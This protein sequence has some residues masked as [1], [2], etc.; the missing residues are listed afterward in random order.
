MASLLG[1][2]LIGRYSPWATPCFLTEEGKQG[3]DSYFAQAVAESEKPALRDSTSAWFSALTVSYLIHVME[4]KQTPS[5][6]P[7]HH[8]QQGL[9]SMP[10]ARWWKQAA[11]NSLSR[12]QLKS[13]PLR[14]QSVL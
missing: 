6:A 5:F 11:L 7:L 1:L 12:V 9:L 13:L 8:D 2:P 10:K 14:G 3:E 4:L